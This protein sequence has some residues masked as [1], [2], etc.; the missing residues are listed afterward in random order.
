MLHITLP[1]SVKSIPAARRAARTEC[2]AAG[3]RPD[4]CDVFELLTSELVSNAVRHSDGRHIEVTV[5]VAR[6]GPHPPEANRLR[7]E[8]ADRNPTLPTLREPVLE[9]ENGRGIQLVDLLSAAWGA[10]G[11]GNGKIV[12]FELSTDGTKPPRRSSS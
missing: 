1:A 10:A 4:L 11:N 9:A 8:V 7:V 3:Y 2:I 6:G 12:W 5:T